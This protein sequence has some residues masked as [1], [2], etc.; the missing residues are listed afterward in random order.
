MLVPAQEVDLATVV[1]ELG[2]DP[3]Y[4][5]G[6]RAPSALR[7]AVWPVAL[8]HLSTSPGRTVLDDAQAGRVSQRVRALPAPVPDVPLRA[9]VAMVHDAYEAGSDR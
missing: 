3:G 7:Q 9:C 4:V 5:P 1:R 8:A 6:S 2:L